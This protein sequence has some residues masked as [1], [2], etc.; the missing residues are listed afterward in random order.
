MDQDKIDSENIT[1]K[2]LFSLSCMNAD[3]LLKFSKEK[4]DH[5]EVNFPDSYTLSNI[6]DIMAGNINKKLKA[7]NCRYEVE[8]RFVNFR[9]LTLHHKMRNI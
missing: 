3:K 9:S 5:L 2:L 7:E 8:H 1:V 4:I 6:N